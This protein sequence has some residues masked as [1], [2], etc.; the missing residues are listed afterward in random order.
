LSALVGIPARLLPIQDAAPANQSAQASHIDYIPDGSSPEVSILREMAAV[1]SSPG[2]LGPAL[3]LAKSSADCENFAAV[4][5]YLDPAHTG[6]ADQRI[7]RFP[8]ARER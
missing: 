1:W 7:R 8:A 2:G 6:N 5:L 4:F 3:A